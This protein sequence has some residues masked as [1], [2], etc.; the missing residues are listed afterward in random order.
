MD[1]FV[2]LFHV[3]QCDC[4]MFDKAYSLVEEQDFEG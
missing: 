2:T 1:K 4:Y 3:Y